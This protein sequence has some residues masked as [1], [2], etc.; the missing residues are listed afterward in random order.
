MYENCYIRKD[1]T[2]KDSYFSLKR[3]IYKK[4]VNNI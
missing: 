2:E 1:F 4:R 3:Y